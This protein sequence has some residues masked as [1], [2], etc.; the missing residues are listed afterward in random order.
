M[1]EQDPGSGLPP[2]PL[3]QRLRDA[4]RARTDSVELSDLRPA[5]PPA[6][7]VRFRLSVSR[8]VRRTVALLALAAVV[9]AVLLVSARWERQSPTIP[10]DTPSVSP[11]P[12]DAV[13]ASPN[14]PDD[15]TDAVPQP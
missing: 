9:A 7:Q 6:R 10:A 12:T 1:I 15:G 2:D 8:P 11:T 5:V 3:E 14:P 4:L 13:N